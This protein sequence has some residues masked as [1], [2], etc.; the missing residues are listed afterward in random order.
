MNLQ[1]LCLN[2]VCKMIILSNTKDLNQCYVIVN[3]IN[4]IP[5][6]LFLDLEK[7]FF[8]CHFKYLD[9]TSELQYM[10]WYIMFLQEKCSKFW[11]NENVYHPSYM[12]YTLPLIEAAKRNHKKVFKLLLDTLDDE[13]KFV[14]VNKVERNKFSYENKDGFLAE[15]N[16]ALI[17]ACEN[18]NVDIVRM[19]IQTLSY[20]NQAKRVDV[21]LRD[22]SEIHPVCCAPNR[23]QNINLKI[24][25][26]ILNAADIDGNPAACLTHKD[27]ISLLE[28]VCNYGDVNFVQFLTRKLGEQYVTNYCLTGACENHEYGAEILKMLLQNHPQLDV[29]HYDEVENFT[30]FLAACHHQNIEAVKVLLETLNNVDASKRIDINL[31]GASGFMKGKKSGLH[32]AVEADSLEITTLILDTLKFEDPE[33][34]VDVKSKNGEN[35]TSLDLAKELDNTDIYNILLPYYHD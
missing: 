1:E 5:N 20:E 12:M 33:R 26:L 9:Q 17:A 2:K 19:L 3:Y 27:K 6:Q 24:T 15:H 18:E 16:T 8:K 28:Y 22:S 10:T 13:E 23:I 7:Q 31:Q 29:N 32:L 25:K 4:Q 34:R 14:D 21:N 35:Q 11:L 30:P